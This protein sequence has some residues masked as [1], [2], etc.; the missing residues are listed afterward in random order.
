MAKHI[1]SV[2]F[3]L[4]N[5]VIVQQDGRVVKE[6]LLMGPL[7]GIKIETVWEG[8]KLITVLLKSGEK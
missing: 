7:G 3:E 1:D 4:K 6:S 5:I 8:E 2:F